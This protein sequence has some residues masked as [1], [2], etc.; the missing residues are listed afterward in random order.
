[1]PQR[2]A[3]IELL[4]PSRAIPPATLALAPLLT[5]GSYAARALRLYDYF[6]PPTRGGSSGY[7]KLTPAA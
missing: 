2:L 5:P 1:M 6:L 4:V 3:G 7:F